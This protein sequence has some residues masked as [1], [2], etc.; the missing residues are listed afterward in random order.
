[1]CWKG[2]VPYKTAFNL[3]K[4]IE[5]RSGSARPPSGRWR[6]WMALHPT[7]VTQKV[8][9]I[10]EHFSKQRRAPARWQ[11][12]G[13]GGDQLAGRRRALQEGF[14]AYLAK[15]PEHA[16]I[17]SLVAFSGKLT[18]KQVPMHADDEQFKATYRSSS[19]RTRSSPRRR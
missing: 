19:T 5:D 18:G 14:D 1:M 11:G 17:H 12:Q 7:N 6:K 16:H 9:F 4:Q 10:I 3:A 13:D 15:H 2:Y 8:Q